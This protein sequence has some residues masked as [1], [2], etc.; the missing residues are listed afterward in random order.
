MDLLE[1]TLP[2]YDPGGVYVPPV[3]PR[4]GPAPSLLETATKLT[5]PATA[6]S[7]HEIGHAL[8]CLVR[9]V[10]FTAAVVRADESG[11]V[12]RGLADRRPGALTAFEVESLLLVAAAGPFA[13]A[14]WWCGDWKQ[15]P[16]LASPDDRQAIATC[17]RILRD[18]F[19]AHPLPPCPFVAAGGLLIQ[20][21]V[22]KAVGP[23]AKLLARV[24]TLPATA[25]RRVADLCGVVPAERPVTAPVPAA[26]PVFMDGI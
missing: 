7:Y 14:M 22:N 16:H 17:T 24:G 11:E 21:A 23:L 12:V 20:P 19:P 2:H 26:E 6:A 13:E 25:V 9:S 5:T 15:A 4:A 18:D 3:T 10:P 8:V 1:S